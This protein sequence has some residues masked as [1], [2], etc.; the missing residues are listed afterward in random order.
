VSQITAVFEVT[1][2]CL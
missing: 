1:S 2:V